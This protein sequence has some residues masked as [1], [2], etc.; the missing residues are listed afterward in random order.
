MPQTTTIKNQEKNFFLTRLDTKSIE[1]NKDDIRLFLVERNELPRLPYFLE[2]YRTLGVKKFFIVDDKSNDGSREY[3]LKQNDCYIFDPSNTFKDSRAGVDWQNL[4]LNTYGTGYWTIVADADELLVYPHMEEIKLSHL[5]EYLDQE[6][7]MALFGFLLDMYPKGDLSTGICV[8]GKP[9]FEICPYFDSK[10][11]FRKI[12][13][14]NSPLHELPRVR[15]VGGPR[16]RLFYP[17]QNHVNFFSRL[18]NTAIIKTCD[19][20]KFIKEDKPH[21]A[22]ALIKM[23]LVKWNTG[24]TRLSNHVIS[25]PEGAKISSLT[26]A[27]MHFK[28]FA[29]F[30]DKAKSEVA[31]GVHFGGSLEYR[32]YLKHTKKNPNLILHYQGSKRFEGST[33]L[34]EAGLIQSNESFEA[35]RSNLRSPKEAS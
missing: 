15:V 21:Y 33:S 28:F 5:C 30:H 17:L 13:T 16:T 20:L 18:L 26:G 1:E 6:G 27:I 34:I 4:L 7:S 25:A 2:Y 12:G 24:I 3:L 35:Y 23:P 19:L 29:D 22:P 14:F 11:L 9:F 8:S 10:Y 32:R 31:R